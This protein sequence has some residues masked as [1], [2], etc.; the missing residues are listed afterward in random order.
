MKLFIKFLFSITNNILAMEILITIIGY[1]H[2]LKNHLKGWAF[3]NITIFISFRKYNNL[4]FYLF[5]EQAPLFANFQCSKID[6]NWS[7]FKNDKTLQ[8]LRWIVIFLV[9]FFFPYQLWSIPSQN[10][11]NPSTN[12]WKKKRSWNWCNSFLQ[13]IWTPLFQ[14]CF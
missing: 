6:V 10:S 14:M 5:L 4:D 1:I 8:T 2:N 7:C 3:I 11:K 9:N 13:H 12:Y